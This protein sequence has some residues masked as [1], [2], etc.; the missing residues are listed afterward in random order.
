MHLKCTSRKWVVGMG[1]GAFQEVAKHYCE[2]LLCAELP[3]DRVPWPLYS[4]LGLLTGW[5]G[6]LG[7][8]RS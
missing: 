6:E 4:L 7:G 5:V 2:C 8:P 1:G 3:G